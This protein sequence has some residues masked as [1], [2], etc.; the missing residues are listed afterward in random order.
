MILKFELHK[1]KIHLQITPSLIKGS[2][3]CKKRKNT[4]F[5]YTI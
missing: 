1:F 2:I 5:V 3:R 4:D